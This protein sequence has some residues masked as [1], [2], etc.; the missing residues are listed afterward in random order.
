MFQGA[1]DE[2]RRA[3]AA[4]GFGRYRARHA[5]APRPTFARPI[6]QLVTAAQ[7][8]EP[9]YARCAAALRLPLVLHRKQ[10]EFAVTLQALDAAGLL[11]PGARGLGFGV[12]A[13]PLPAAF[14]ALGC[15]V[16]LTDLDP[17]EARRRGWSET[18]ATDLS[19]YNR[20]GVCDQELFARRARWTA[21]DMNAVPEDLRRGEFDF[22]WSSCALEHLGSLESGAR[23]VLSSLE[24]L[25][26]G[27]MAVHTTEYNA[28]SNRFT[29]DHA[30]TVLFRERDV[31]ALLAACREAGAAAT[32]TPFSGDEPADRH[33]D[34]PPHTG[35]PHLKLRLGRFVSTSVSLVLRKTTR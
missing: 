34:P 26:P 20:D 6:C 21:V 27:G 31:E 5:E 9:E 7:F 22:V 25:R 30:P 16:V 10:W 15:E 13:E 1:K 12:G 19:A 24:C 18:P 8:R 17:E 33:V 14:A 11:R 2:A 29:Y 23:F 32:F 3:C 35:L 4:F 28:S